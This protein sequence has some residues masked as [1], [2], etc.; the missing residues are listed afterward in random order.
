MGIALYLT[1]LKAQAFQVLKE[2]F[3]SAAQR[4]CQ[5]SREQEVQILSSS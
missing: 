1:G 3:R 4:V 5:I 2:N